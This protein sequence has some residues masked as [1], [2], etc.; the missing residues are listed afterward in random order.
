MKPG[1]NPKASEQ[2]LRFKASLEAL[3]NCGQSNGKCGKLD[4]RKPT[5][6]MI[7]IPFDIGIFNQIFDREASLTRS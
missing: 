2:P 6:K 7:T 4:A 3:E 1:F 5:E